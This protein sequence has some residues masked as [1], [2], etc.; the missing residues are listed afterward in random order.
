[1]LDVPG[2]GRGGGGGGGGGATM[3]AVLGSGGARGG[4]TLDGL[5]FCPGNAEHGGTW[6]GVTVSETSEDS[7]MDDV[8][9]EEAASRGL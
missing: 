5:E 8:P 2:R 3:H 6:A 7:G 1:M 9:E 4:R